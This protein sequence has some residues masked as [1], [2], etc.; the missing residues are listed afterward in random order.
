MEMIFS[1]FGFKNEKEIK[2]YETFEMDDE[3]EKA[4]K[5]TD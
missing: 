1:F 4:R 3:F 2:E 5:I